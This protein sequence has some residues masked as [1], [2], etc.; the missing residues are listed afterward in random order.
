MR[1]LIILMT[2]MLLSGCYHQH[3]PEEKNKY[4]R[5]NPNDKTSCEVTY[6][7]YWDGNGTF[8]EE[9]KDFPPGVEIQANVHCSVQQGYVLKWE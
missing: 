4:E 8:I 9:Q 5:V 3:L 7:G 6:E 2:V 1:Y